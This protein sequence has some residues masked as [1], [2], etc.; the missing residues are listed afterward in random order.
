[1]SNTSSVINWD[2]S[3]TFKAAKK[4]FSVRAAKNGLRYKISSSH[5]VFYVDH[6]GIPISKTL[7]KAFQVFNNIETEEDNDK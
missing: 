7:G 4:G 1:M 2:K 3:I 6:S 5:F